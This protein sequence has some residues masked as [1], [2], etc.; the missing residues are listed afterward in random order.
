ML[1]EAIRLLLHRMNGSAWVGESAITTGGI[2]GMLQ[3]DINR[4]IETW[5]ASGD[6]AGFRQVTATMHAYGKLTDTDY[7]QIM[8]VLDGES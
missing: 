6:M 1:P 7:T 2:T 3:R 5:H 8:E 4:A